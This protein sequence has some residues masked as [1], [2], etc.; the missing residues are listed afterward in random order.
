MTAPALT[1]HEILGLVAPFARRGRHVDLAA[2]DRAAR[3]LVFKAAEQATADPGLHEILTLDSFGT[4]TF[5]LTRV[6]TRP[7]GIQA[8]LQ[9]IGPE[10]G[11]LLDRVE[12]VAPARQFQVD[13]G[14]VVARSY[15][16][17]AFDDAVRRDVGAVPLKL[18][19]GHVQVDGL[20]LTLMVP[21][22]RGVS[23]D[24]TL[25]PGPGEPPALPEDLLAVLGWDWARLIRGRSDWTSKLR[26]RGDA[27]RRS[28]S[29]EQA[30]DRAAIHL[31]QVLS[32]P[33]GCFHD[34]H[35]RARWGVVFRRAIPL[36]TV[37]ALVAMVLLL[38]Y[39]PVHHDPRFM[40]GLHYVPVVLL[41]FGYYLQELPRFEI[42]P[43][44]RRDMAPAWRQ[45]PPPADGQE[46]PIGVS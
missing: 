17:D 28:R 43:R 3:R 23:A 46:A 29:A 20:Q 19:R 38:P 1:H 8:S 41:G 10:P 21:M 32:E 22:V 42:P 14:F 34:R 24:L 15:E 27:A 18:C 7:D 16:L 37:V 12:A 39:L 13:P 4:G 45:T 11:A 2:S 30:L 5:Q 36:L 9:A 44:P 31:A 35:L 33:P 25:Q 40:L 26:L 6:L